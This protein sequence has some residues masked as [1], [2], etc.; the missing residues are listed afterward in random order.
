M[1]ISLVKLLMHT[2]ILQN[3]KVL[4]ENWSWLFSRKVCV[5]QLH[6]PTCSGILE[7][8]SA[9]YYCIF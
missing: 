9:Y 5:R 7:F 6:V 2:W 3:A 4:K 1:N 8:F